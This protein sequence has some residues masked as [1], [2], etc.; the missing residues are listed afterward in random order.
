VS[1]SIF[2]LIKVEKCSFHKA[3]LPKRSNR[4]ENKQTLFLDDEMDDEM[5]EMDDEI[6]D[7]DEE[8]DERATQAA[9]QFENIKKAISNLI[10]D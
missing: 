5:D 2:F 3:E 10:L 4:R 9:T 1:K 7:E 6:L 8:E